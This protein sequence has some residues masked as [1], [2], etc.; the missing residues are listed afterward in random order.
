MDHHVADRREEQ[1]FLTDFNRVPVVL[2]MLLLSE[3]FALILTAARPLGVDPWI[4]FALLSLFMLWVGI[5]CSIV[6]SLLRP[7]LVRLR[8]VAAMLI[9][10]VAVVGT[11]AALTEAA[12]QV[13]DRYLALIDLGDHAELLV[14][15]TFIGALMALIGLRYFYIHHQ[16]Q[17]RVLSEGEYRLMALQ[18][19]I[20]PHFLFN[21]MNTIASL[22][23]NQPQLAEE[24]VEDLADLFRASLNTG[25]RLSSLEDELFLVRSYLHLE[26]LRLGERLTVMW[27]LDVHEDGPR[28]PPLILQ[29]L[30]ENAVY[31]GIEPLGEPGT[32]TIRSVFRKGTLLIEV[33][34]PLPDGGSRS[35]STGHRI[36]Q[37]NIRQR[38]R[39]HYGSAADLVVHRI[40]GRY[41]ATLQIPW[42]RVP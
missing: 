19:R 30:V 10:Y 9:A 4:D 33:E 16:W 27:Q 41:R 11:V 14:R 32:L 29:P 5:G 24:A 21:S 1:F 36:A 20:R 31:H 38:L 6:L 7:V 18:A 25:Q 17:L 13:V 28:I 3:L 12:Y 35:R 34:N 22:V 39:A 8:P 23:R 40:E 15:N 26:Q 37:D 2:T 42:R